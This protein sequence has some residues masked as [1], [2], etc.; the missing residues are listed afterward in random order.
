M[1]I[2]DFDGLADIKENYLE[3]NK[4]LEYVPKGIPA[5]YLISNI[6]VAEIYRN[7]VPGRQTGPSVLVTKI[8]RLYPLALYRLAET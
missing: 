3:T 6:C 2:S 7:G 4:E 1:D 5:V 8:Q